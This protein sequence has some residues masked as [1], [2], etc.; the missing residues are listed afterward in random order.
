MASLKFYRGHLSCVAVSPL[1]VVE[2]LDVIE[3]IGPG[4]L[5]GGIDA[6]P[7]SLSFEQLEEALGHGVVVAVTA[8]THAGLEF[9]GLQEVTPVVA[10]ELT[11]LVA[12]DDDLI[13]GAPAPDG[14]QQGVEHQIAVDATAHGP[15]HHGAGEEI[16]HH[17]QIQPSLVRADVG[18]VGD[19]RLIR[20]RHIKLLLQ[21]IVSHQ[22][23]TSI[24]IAWASCVSGLRAQPILAHVPRLSMPATA[25]TMIP[26]IVSDLAIAVEAIA[27]LPALTDELHQ[28][29]I[30][31][32]SGAV[33]R[34]TPG[35]VAAGMNIQHSTHTPHREDGC[36]IPDKGVLHWDCFAK[37]A[38]VY[39]TG[40]CNTWFIL[41]TNGG[42]Y[43]K[44]N[45]TKI[46]RYGAGPLLDT[47]ALR[48]RL[49]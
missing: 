45:Q 36:V 1:R 40:L 28:P 25:L 10:A 47:L 31:Q 22:A 7:D 48:A 32:G 11:A 41:A 24:P 18:A 14:G 20:R 30:L 21:E 6:A 26:Q 9:V 49:Q 16:Q 4:L 27:V 43:E 17:G 3:D 34:T 2:H 13:L 12:V 46:Y 15:T 37:Y 39:S 29:P 19:P 5:P 35:V 8:P 33:W 23:G 42:V 38:A 44:K